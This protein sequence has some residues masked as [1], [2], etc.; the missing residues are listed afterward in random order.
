M[1][2]T[3]I[4]VIDGS[5][6][7]GGGQTLRTSL[8]LSV[9]TGRPVEINRIRA[10]RSR[11]GLQPQHLAAVRAAAAISAAQT[12]GAEPGSTRLLFAPQS[13]AAPGVYHF[14]IGTA[15]AATLV[16]QTVLLPLAR[17]GASSR[18]TVIGG[19]HVPYAP[20]SD[21]LSDVY[22]VML[23][24][25]GLR[26]DITVPIAGFLPRG[27]GRLELD[28]RPSPGW[29]PVTLTERGPLHSITA[30]VLTAA[31][32]PDVAARGMAALREGLVKVKADIRVTHRETSS[33][34]SG[35]AVFL[36]AESGTCRAGFSAL[37]ARGKPIEAVA[38]EA[39]AAFDRW[40][41]TGAACEDHL[42]DQLVLP[43]ALTSGHSR[44]TTSE[45]TE[46]LR[47]V[48]WVVPQ[49]LDVEVSLEENT[50]GSGTVSLRGHAF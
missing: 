39:V 2:D 38:G 14:E 9:L 8:S 4:V 31:L 24:D 1:T 20:P 34:G 22:A 16:A 30:T 10:G 23:S 41:Q 11:S 43:M 15:G 29:T 27:G 50:D 40:H 25:H 12:E 46:H 7:E 37:G 45:V 13:P 18:V 36:T 19:T 47:T 28:I 44:W 48:L 3:Q 17:A 35:A 49:F 33:L 6:G 5:H 42:A 32:P 26:M 21:Y